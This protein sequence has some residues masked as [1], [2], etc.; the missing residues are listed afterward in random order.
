MLEDPAGTVT[1]M[2]PRARQEMTM[3]L[4]VLSSTPN[5]SFFSQMKKPDHSQDYPLSEDD[6]ENAF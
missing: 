4:K 6:I 2:Q 3:V 1:L 5:H